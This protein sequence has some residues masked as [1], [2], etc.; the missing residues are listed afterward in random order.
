MHCIFLRSVRQIETK[1]RLELAGDLAAGKDV[2]LAAA[3]GDLDR[4]DE[5]G[6]AARGRPIPALHH[7]VEQ[8]CA[9][10]VAAASR[11]DHCAGRDCRNFMADAAGVNL[12]AIGAQRDNQRLDLAGKL[13]QRETGAVVT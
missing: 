3:A 2:I 8:A 1:S 7:A 11:V 5:A 12:R 10:S 9:E 4:A 6:Q 13:F